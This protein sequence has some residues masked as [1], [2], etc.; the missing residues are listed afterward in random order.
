MTCQ[1]LDDQIAT[2][3]TN[4]GN[5]NAQ[6]SDKAGEIDDITAV[7]I[8]ADTYPNG[9]PSIP[10]TESSIDSRVM[11]LG[12][13]KM[14]HPALAGAIDQLIEKYNKTT[15]PYGVKTLIQQKASLQTQASGIQ[16]QIQNL[17][18]QKQIQGCP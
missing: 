10:F 3:L 4:L 6:I 7:I 15:T 16:L 8:A 1:E 17:R 14:M 12:M 18:N 2:E 13:Y 5:V 9:A 11:Y